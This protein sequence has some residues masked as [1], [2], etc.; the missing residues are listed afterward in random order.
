MNFEVALVIGILVGLP[1]GVWGGM[2]A[3]FWL[4]DRFH[5]W[6]P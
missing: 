4:S 2:M 6:F 5:K 3:Y 1:F